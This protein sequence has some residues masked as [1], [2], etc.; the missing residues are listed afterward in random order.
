MHGNVGFIQQLTTKG[1]LKL[2]GCLKFALIWILKVLK[3]SVSIHASKCFL[4]IWKEKRPFS[5]WEM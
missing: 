4:L 5:H 3:K 2:S 1:M